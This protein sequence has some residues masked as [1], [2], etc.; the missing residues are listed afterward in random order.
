M[1]T[2]L[3]R[4]R[5]AVGR[6]HRIHPE[7]QGKGIGSMLSSALGEAIL[8]HPSIQEIMYVKLL[9]GPKIC[10]CP[11]GDYTI[12]ITKPRVSYN[13]IDHSGVEAVS[14]ALEKYDVNTLRWLNDDEAK[15]ALTSPHVGRRLFPDDVILVDL[16]PYRR[17]ADVHAIVVDNENPYV[18]ADDGY[19]SLSFGTAFPLADDF[20]V[21]YKIDVYARDAAA[22]RSHVARHARLA[23]AIFDGKS[24]AFVVCADAR[25]R[26]VRA[27]VFR[28]VG[29]AGLQESDVGRGGGQYQL[30]AAVDAR[31]FAESIKRDAQS[32]PVTWQWEPGALRMR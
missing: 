16:M 7:F 14:S 25:L 18:L 30:I 5:T 10:P 26:D 24:V 23:A 22:A 9:T 28:A 15:Y 11:Y 32:N 2:M 17:A 19:A 20:R 6:F 31:D 13:A 8:N 12:A 27:D 21:R 3:N 29:E 4:G 1:A